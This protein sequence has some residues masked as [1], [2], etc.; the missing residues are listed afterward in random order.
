MFKRFHKSDAAA[1]GEQGSAG[2]ETSNVVN[3]NTKSVETQ[4]GSA[5]ISVLGDSNI[6]QPAAP[7]ESQPIKWEGDARY[8]QTGKKQGQL[9]PSMAVAGADAEGAESSQ[10][11]GL[12]VGALKASVKKKAEA[13]PVSEAKNAK[14]E[15]KATE[16]KIGAKMAIRVLDLIVGF[17][18]KNQYGKD[19]N[20]QQRKDRNDYR[21][22]L[23]KDWE[24]YLV[25]LDIPMHPALVVA[26]GSIMYTADAFNT[27]AGQERVQTLTEKIGGKLFGFMLGRKK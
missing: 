4:T 26:F 1:A 17:I 6:Q 19:F 2:S 8:Y 12:N 22:S 3:E 11:G 18:S 24:D 5:N 23:E 20:E 15:K 10:F 9:R 13:A 16:A 21:A 25:T 27:P 7:A 14:A